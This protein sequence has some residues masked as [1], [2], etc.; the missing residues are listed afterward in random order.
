MEQAPEDR[1]LEFVVGEQDAG[2]RL[3]VF[4]AAQGVCTRSAAQNLIKNESVSLD[5]TLIDTPSR[6]LKA[7]QEVCVEL[8][9]AKP[10][11]AQPED[12]PLDILYEDS[13]VIVIN[14]PRGM[15]VH[16]APGNESGTLVNALLYHCK[17]LSGING[18]Q[19][20]GIV[21][22]LDKDTT[23]ALSVAKNDKAH[24]SLAL[25]ISERTMHRCYH[26]IV[27]GRFR[28]QSGFVEANIGRHPIHRKKMAVVPDGRWALTN[29]RV[30][31]EF[32]A[33]YTLLELRLKTGRTHQIR[34]H[35]AHIGHPVANDPLYAPNGK[36]LPALPAQ[37]LHAYEL[38]F[39]H[40]KTGEDVMTHAPYP[41]DF[42]KALDFLRAGG[43]R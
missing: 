2:S 15:V 22:R 9:E 34:V 42:Q 29:W 37:A 10:L 21:H 41:E 13:D 1:I 14:K 26:A 3:D 36:K 30:L 28:E 19:R 25:Q 12:I 5:G 7:G 8:P 33:P 18:V 16:P 17:D 43:G 23:G 35:M 27:Q 4:L 20:P 11:E 40:P 38:G 24:E 32:D 31:E 6:K 39:V